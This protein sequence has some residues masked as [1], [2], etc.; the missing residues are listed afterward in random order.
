MNQE[1]CDR[2]SVVMPCH[3]AAAYVAQAIESVLAQT[4]PQVELVVVD[5]GSTDASPQVMQRYAERI[6]IVHQANTGAAAAR[7]RGI[8]LASGR[9]LAF[10]DADDYWHPRFL[11]RMVGAL[12]ASA[13]VLAYCGWFIVE[14]DGRERPPFI[15][16]DYENERKLEHLLRNASLWPIHGM[17]TYRQ[18]VIEAGMFD[19]R[20]PVCED[21]DLWLR[22]AGEQP[23]VRVPEA[24]AFYRWHK[25]LHETDKRAVDADYI[26]RIKRA[27]LS[28]HP[29]LYHR[30]SA[31][32]VHD[33][34][35]GGYI[36]RGRQCL[37][38]GEYKSA[39]RIFRTVWRERA[40]RWRDLP[41][42]LPALLPEPWFRVLARSP[43]S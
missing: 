38:R 17:L 28:A 16:P 41:Y 2:V 12:R 18:A 11:E 10:L 36:R 37:Q 9:Y 8:A 14:A 24:L 42:V 35:E 23:I 27:Y 39:Q 25:P 4:W 26:R 29:D 40:Y 15:P 1:E 32:V 7:N 13:A 20:W 21:Y 3:N 22:L 43:K 5:D 6:R 19:P 33:C 30:L 34:I 31:K